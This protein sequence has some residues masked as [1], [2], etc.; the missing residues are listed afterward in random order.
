MLTKQ[1]KIDT[2]NVAAG[3]VV[4]S[5]RRLAMREETEITEITE[6]RRFRPSHEWLKFIV[7][8]VVLMGTIFVVALIRPYIFDRII[9]VIMGEGQRT[10][11]MPV[12]EPVEELDG[13][14]EAYP[15]EEPASPPTATKDIA[16]EGEAYPV[17]SEPIVENEVELPTAVPTTSHTV[18][19]GD[20]MISI[21]RQYDVTVEAIIAANNIS[22]PNHIEVGTTLLI[23]K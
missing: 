10:A 15:V 6:R 22:D 3:N 18:Q 11:P 16:A 7:L 14:E 5:F 4:Y 21:A 1:N 23:P 9:P 20:T 8:A 17:E 12:E 2:L 19:P 13:G